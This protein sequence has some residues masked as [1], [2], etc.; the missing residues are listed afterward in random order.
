MMKQNGLGYEEIKKLMSVV[1]KKKT[2]I[3]EEKIECCRIEE[4]KAELIRKL[5]FNTTKKDAEIIDGKKVKDIKMPKSSRRLVLPKRI[6][7]VIAKERGV[8]N[9]ENLSRSELIK[10]I[11]KL[12]P[13][14]EPKNIV[15]EKYPKKR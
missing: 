13:E 2:E 6:L 5:M 12:K 10:E 1:I 4:K 3:I 14:K 9:Y 11:N 7:K 15:F 8:K